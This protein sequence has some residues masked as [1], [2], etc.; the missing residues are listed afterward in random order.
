[1]RIS[2]IRKA[3]EYINKALEYDPRNHLDNNSMNLYADRLALRATIKLNKM[4]LNNITLEEI[5][6]ICKE[7]EEDIKNAEQIYKNFG[8]MGTDKEIHYLGRLY[9]TKVFFTLFKIEKNIVQFD[10][11]NYTQLFEDAKKAHQKRVPYGILAGKYCDAYCHYFFYHKNMQ[12]NIDSNIK[13]EDGLKL[14]TEA[15][16][17]VVKKDEEFPFTMVDTKITSLELQIAKLL[18]K[19]DLEEYKERFNAAKKKLQNKGI[20]F[21]QILDS[22][23][24]LRK[25]LGTPIN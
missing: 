15:K 12:N 14:L 18:K 8:S 20:T 25:W 23:E 9:G 7:I 17:A 2:D 16:I 10:M 22:E 6:L 5:K 3:L 13:L 1:M 21:F 4:I 24:N 19:D 11:R